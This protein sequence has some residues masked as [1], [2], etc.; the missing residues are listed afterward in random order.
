MSNVTYLAPELPIPGNGRWWSITLY[1][2]YWELQLLEHV[3]R[4]YYRDTAVVAEAT[5]PDDK[6][7]N[8]EDFVRE[9]TNILIRLA[10]AEAFVGEYHK[11]ESN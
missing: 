9:A 7:T 2:E 4:D 5:I 1:G 11:E 10:K 6:Y 8:A 3:E